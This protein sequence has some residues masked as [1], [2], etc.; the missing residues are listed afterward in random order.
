MLALT[1]YLTRPRRTRVALYGALGALYGAAAMSLVRFSLRRVGLIDKM[2][3]QALTEWAANK[4]GA[5][6][7]V[8][9][10]G[11]PVADQLVHLGY[12]VGWGGIAAPVLFA[13]GQRQ[14]LAIGSLFGLG[15]WAIGPMA[16]FPLLRIARPAWKSSATENFT[17]LATHLIY[18]LAVQLVTEEAVRQRER[19]AS[20]DMT[21]HLARVG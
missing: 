18:G 15:L 10:A 16:L 13:T 20:S 5:E 12:S 4:L 8:V 14:N 19:G 21:R 7:P 17:N 1:K 11:H 3:P 9:P 2:V 6:P